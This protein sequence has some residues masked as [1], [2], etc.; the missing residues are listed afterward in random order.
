MGL[1]LVDS[2]F[3]LELAAEEDSP[4]FNRQFSGSRAIDITSTKNPL[5]FHVSSRST[6][7]TTAQELKYFVHASLIPEK[8]ASKPKVEVC[9]IGSFER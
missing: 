7:M 6:Y 4:R 3:F 9:G 2:P 1:H 8:D 5:F